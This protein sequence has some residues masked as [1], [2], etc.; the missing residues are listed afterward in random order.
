MDS[1]AFLAAYLAR[2]DAAAVAADVPEDRRAEL[3]SDVREH[4][5]LAIADLGPDADGG[6]DAVVARLG[7]PEEIVDAE[8][9]VN[10]PPD[11]A[12]MRREVHVAASPKPWHPNVSTES[13]ALL[14]LV[15]GGT[16]LPFVG[17]L[18]G[19]WFVWSS[20]LWTVVQKRTATVA[21]SV[22]LALP[23][24]IVVPILIAGEVTAV[25]NN[26][27]PVLAMIPLSGILTAA[28]LA[29]VLHVE[30]LIVERRNP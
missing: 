16:I 9:A 22:L 27:G 7:T 12:D 8:M 24:T 26:F 17:S 29:V 19:L 14:W 4:L 28:Y 23:A 25:I 10:G 6:L 20:T 5:E 1:D 21:V 18:I 3:H 13:K 2:L 15:V 11:N 30:I